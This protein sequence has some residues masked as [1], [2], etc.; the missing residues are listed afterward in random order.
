MNNNIMIK[1]SKDT[2]K[3]ALEKIDLGAKTVT[4]SL[5]GVRSKDGS[6]KINFIT[7]I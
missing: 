3:E 6:N 1:I 5:P 7:V 2:L 4:L